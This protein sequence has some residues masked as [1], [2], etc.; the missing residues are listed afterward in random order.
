M[1]TLFPLCIN[2]TK[3]LVG[4]DRGIVSCAST[5]SINRGRKETTMANKRLWQEVVNDYYNDANYWLIGEVA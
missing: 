2:Y 1:P 5:I 3:V 4:G